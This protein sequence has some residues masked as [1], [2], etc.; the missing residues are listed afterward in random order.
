MPWRSSWAGNDE[1]GNPNVRG[2]PGFIPDFA[3]QLRREPR[4]EAFGQNDAQQ[5]NAGGDGF[6]GAGGADNLN[7]EEGAIDGG[8]AGEVFD[9]QKIKITRSLKCPLVRIVLVAISLNFYFSMLCDCL[10][11]K[12]LHN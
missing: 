9:D 12:S 6:G 5:Q 4:Q 3:R 1:D 8:V 7:A 2:G 10:L 11:N